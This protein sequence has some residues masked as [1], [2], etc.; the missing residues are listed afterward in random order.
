MHIHS[1]HSIEN[2]PERL[3]VVSKPQ[4]RSKGPA[5]RDYMSDLGILRYAS[6][7]RP[8]GKAQSRHRRDEPY[9]YRR[10]DEHLNIH[11]NRCEIPPHRRGNAAIGPEMG[12]CNHF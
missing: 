3:E 1:H 12:F 7:V 4:I 9:I 10:P 5:K 6:S 11:T 2:P 8:I